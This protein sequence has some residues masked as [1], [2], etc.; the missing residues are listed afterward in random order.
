M[1]RKVRRPVAAQFKPA[2]RRQ[3]KAVC[4]TGEK[5]GQKRK[6]A[7]QA[8]EKPLP[9]RKRGAKRRRHIVYRR[10]LPGNFPVLPLRQQAR[11]VRM[12]AGRLSRR[13]AA[14]A[15][16]LVMAAIANHKKKVASLAARFN[17]SRNPRVL[18][19]FLREQNFLKTLRVL[20]GMLV[21][22]AGPLALQMRGREPHSE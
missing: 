21:E 9:Q 19:W 22:E 15:L 3:G 12:L 17:K 11:A 6:P 4:G 13:D 7:S 2:V 10:S 8:G 5:P 20:G 14:R 18:M 1:L 16:P